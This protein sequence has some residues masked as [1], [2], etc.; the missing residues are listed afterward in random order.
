MTMTGQSIAVVQLK[1]ACCWAVLQLGLVA[2]DWAETGL[3]VR[4][5][6]GRGG[7]GQSASQCPQ[8]PDI[9]VGFKLLAIGSLFCK[10]LCKE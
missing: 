8:G 4:G 9:P 2:P 6:D 10:P 1:T 3:G 7:Q 5:A